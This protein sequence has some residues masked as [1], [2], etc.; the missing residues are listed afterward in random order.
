MHPYQKIKIKKNKKLK[1]HQLLSLFFK[2]LIQQ[3]HMCACESTKERKKNRIVSD[4]NGGW[5]AQTMIDYVNH[6]L[7]ISF[8]LLPL[9]PFFILF[10]IWFV[11]SLFVCPLLSLFFFFWESHAPQL[12]GQ[13]CHFIFL[14]SCNGSQ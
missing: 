2:H 12:K 13:V 5:W 6:F 11:H 10:C 9:R 3:V 14:H 1:V 4:R 8:S 7:I